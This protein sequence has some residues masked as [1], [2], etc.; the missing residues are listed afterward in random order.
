MGVD[1][2]LNGTDAG[3]A[4]EGTNPEGLRQIRVPLPEDYDNDPDNDDLPESIRVI[5][6]QC[7]APMIARSSRFGGKPGA[8]YLKGDAGT[9]FNSLRD[10][11]WQNFL[12]G[13]YPKPKVWMSRDRTW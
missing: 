8:F 5:A 10:L 7:G 12:N 4:E 3:K 9:D 6:R 2:F 13:L 11:L 1:L